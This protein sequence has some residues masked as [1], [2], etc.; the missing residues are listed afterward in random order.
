MGP[1]RQPILVKKTDSTTASWPDRITVESEGLPPSYQSGAAR[2]LGMASLFFAT[3]YFLA[4]FVSYL[5]RWITAGTLRQELLSFESTYAWMG[6]LLSLVVFLLSRYVSFAPGRLGDLGLF[7][8]ILGTICI[9]VPNFWGAYSSWSPEIQNQVSLWRIHQGI[10]WECPWIIMFPFVARHFPGRT[11]LASLLAASASPVTLLLSRALGH[12]SAEFSVLSIVWYFLFTTYLSALLGY[13]N[14]WILARLGR[15]LRRARAIGSYVLQDRLGAGG[16]G[17]VWRARHRMLARP[18]AV[19]LIRPEVLGK[20]ETTR[21]NLIRRFERE[22]QAT[23]TLRS[24]HTIEVY[25]FGRTRD[26]AFYYVMELLDGLDL[27]SFVA[28][29]GPLPAER[30]VFLMRQVCHSLGEAHDHGMIHRDI[31]PANIFV[32]RLGPDHDFVKVLDFGLVKPT[33]DLQEDSTRLTQAGFTC[34]TPA[35]LAPE[36]AGGNQQYDHRA[37]IYCL[38]CVGYW[39]MTGE[40]VFDGDSPVEIIAHH[41]HTRPVPPSQRSELIFPP[42]LERVILA[43]LE[44]DPARR[45]ASVTELDRELA[46]CVTEKV[47]TEAEANAWWEQHLAW[48]GG[49]DTPGSTAL[50]DSDRS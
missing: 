16:M 43:C 4:H 29:F 24:Q 22:A 39:L 19:K 17:E 18:A 35:Y 12:T 30:V 40:T 49:G 45:P 9:A 13:F 33:P 2:R 32:C 27:E 21:Q 37:D 31:K 15:D 47:W 5:P 34:G 8:M 10:P 38:G 6:I 14:S 23:A 3:A 46:A 11:L 25:D 20:D 36:M 41:L 1:E 28:R 44:K 42:A 26:G 48:R 50:L 7:Y